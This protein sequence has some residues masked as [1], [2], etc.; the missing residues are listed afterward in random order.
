MRPPIRVRLRGRQRSC[1]QNLLDHAVSPRVRLHA[2][3]VWL[4][5][6]GY[7]APE[8]SQMTHRGE[9]AVRRWLRR[10]QKKGCVGLQESSRSGR[11]PK[12]T[13]SAEKAL[14]QWVQRSPRKYSIDRPAWTTATL[15]KC[16]ERKRHIRVTDECIR[17]H[18]RRVDIVC[19]RPTW[20]VKHRARQEPGYPQKKGQFLGC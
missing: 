8:I 18:L 12:V 15:A 9:D 4:S 7:S 17:K 6:Q 13:A 16:L 2:Q 10:F 5:H 11:P 14:R 19:R 3:M 1:V 20:T